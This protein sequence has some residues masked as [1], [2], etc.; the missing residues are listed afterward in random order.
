M[1]LH[2]C[3]VFK[4]IQ[5]AVSLSD[6]I[7]TR[8]D[9]SEHIALP[10]PLNSVLENKKTIKNNTANM[11]VT[12]KLQFVIVFFSCCQ[13]AYC[14]QADCMVTVSA[15]AVIQPY[16]T[17]GEQL[18]GSWFHRSSSLSNVYQNL[19]EN[20]RV[21]AQVHLVL[22]SILHPA[23]CVNACRGESA[24]WSGPQRE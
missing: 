7:P 3:T 23:K 12:E 10:E 14:V 8:Q 21:N 5:S 2:Q 17:E 24:M 19:K 18:G 9:T 11:I 22:G 15:H 13:S 16:T 20:M 1:I 4:C 6:Y